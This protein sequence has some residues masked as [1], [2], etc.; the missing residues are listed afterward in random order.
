MLRGEDAYAIGHAAELFAA[1]LAA[2]GGQPMDVWRTSGDDDDGAESP[3]GGGGKRRARIL[4]EIE[5]R[6]ATA[7]MF[8]GGTLVVVRQPG[9]LIRES[10]AREQTVLL[11]DAVAPGNALAVADLV[12]SGGR[13]P[14]QAAILRDAVA[15]RDGRGGDS[16][17]PSRERMEGWIGSRAKNSP[18][19]RTGRRTCWR[20]EWALTS[21][22]E[23]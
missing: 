21:A 23:M 15:E 1:E 9:S 2:Q 10:S 8:S 16:P 5:Q 20:S 6:L 12:A 7:P 19:A 22:K 13:G 17:R 3:A 18:G 14:A 4:E 11:L